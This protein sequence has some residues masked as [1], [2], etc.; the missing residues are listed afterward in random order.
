[1]EV[2]HDNGKTDEMKQNIHRNFPAKK[3]QHSTIFTNE[4]KWMPI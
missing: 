2:N 1:M 4:W 3:Q